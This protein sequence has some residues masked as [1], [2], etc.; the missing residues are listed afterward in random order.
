MILY[1][2]VIL[3]PCHKLKFV[4]FSFD[5]I[6]GSVGKND[7][8]KEQVRVGLYEIFDYY[9]LRYSNKLPH[10]S[11]ILCYSSCSFIL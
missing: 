5:K 4:E 2:V 10:T 9:K 7:I 3:D 11:K 8:M 6:Y 1:Y